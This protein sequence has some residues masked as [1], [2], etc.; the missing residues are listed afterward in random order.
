M[1]HH[2]ECTVILY[3]TFHKGFNQGALFMQYI[4]LHQVCL[5]PMPCRLIVK[6]KVKSQNTFILQG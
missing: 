6:V 3:T 4:F 2:S 1:P 5:Q